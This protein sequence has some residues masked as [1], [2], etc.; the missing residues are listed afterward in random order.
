VNSFKKSAERCMTEMDQ[1]CQVIYFQTKN[2]NL[3]KFSRFLCW[4]MLVYFTANWSILL[5]YGIFCGQMVY[6]VAKLYTYFVAKWYI[7]WPNGI[8][9]GQMVYFVAKWYILWPNDIFYGY[10]VYFPPF[11]YV[12][13]RKIWQP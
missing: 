6:F 9:C 4:M 2:T 5:P 8:F 11:W 3:G 1:G 12:V 13:A 10:L 7:S